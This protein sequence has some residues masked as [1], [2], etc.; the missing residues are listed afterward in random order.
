MADDATRKDPAF[1]LY[2]N[3]GQ[4]LYQ[5]EYGQGSR[6]LQKHTIENTCTINGLFLHILNS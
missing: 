4:C 3:D 2:T 1:G 6:L 5:H